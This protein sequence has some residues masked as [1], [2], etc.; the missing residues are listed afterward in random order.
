MKQ[1]AS[2]QNYM[3]TLF[4][5][6]LLLQIAAAS[7]VMFVH[8]SNVCTLVSYITSYWSKQQHANNLH[9]IPLNS[10][11]L[12]SISALYGL[13]SVSLFQLT[14]IYSILCPTCNTIPALFLMSPVL[15]TKY[16][17]QSPKTSFSSTRRRPIYPY[18]FKNFAPL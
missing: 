12:L 1:V 10:T 7:L 2:K 14:K 4:V 6:T 11:L 15:S 3:H 18:N 17:Y 16:F 13:L 5:C 8:E 9:T